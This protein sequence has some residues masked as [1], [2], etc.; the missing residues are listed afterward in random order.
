MIS[1]LNSGLKTIH[2]LMIHCRMLA[3]KD[4]KAE[5]LELIDGVEYL[6]TLLY[7]V[8]NEDE[9]FDIYLKEICSDFGLR[10][11]LNKYLNE[12]KN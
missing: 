11:I 2:S 12:K 3:M 5:L 7:S 9:A 1:K 8:D 10:I 4:K 6:Q